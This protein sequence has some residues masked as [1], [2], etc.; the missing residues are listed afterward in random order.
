MNPPLSFATKETLVQ[1]VGGNLIVEPKLEQDHILGASGPEFAPLVLD[2]HWVKHMPIAELQRNRF[3]DTYM[4]VTFSLNNIHEFLHK[5]LY[6]TEINKSD[7]CLGVMSGTVRGQGNSKRAVVETNR[8]KGFV[9][10]IDYPYTPEMTLDEVYAPISSDLLL[11]ALGNLDHYEFGYKWLAANT[12]KAMIEGLKFSPLQVDVNSRYRMNGKDQVVWNK[13]DPTYDHEVTVF[14]YEQGICWWVF[15]SESLQFIKF[16]WNY[17]FGS[18][19]IHSLKKKMKIE[20]YKKIGSPAIAVKHSS[21]P[22]MIAFSGGSVSGD[23]LFKSIYGVTDFSEIPITQVKEWPF[24]IRHLLN[25]NP[26]R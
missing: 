17:P 6:G 5:R 8:T 15:D 11:K 24:P 21:E 7:I 3:G 14:D 16:D 20:L 18:P 4:C 13:A 9:Y 10:E 26:K 2:G 1:P 22:S 19:M 25:T 23:D 12:P